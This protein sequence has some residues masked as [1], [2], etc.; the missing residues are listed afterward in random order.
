MHSPRRRG[1]THLRVQMDTF[2]GEARP[3]Q[4]FMEYDDAVKPQGG[5]FDVESQAVTDE[6]KARRPSY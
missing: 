5:N 3:Q 6:F 4:S 1:R 2:P